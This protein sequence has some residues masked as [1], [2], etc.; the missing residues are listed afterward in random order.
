MTSEG[1]MFEEFVTFQT[2]E[3]F[4]MENLWQGPPPEND[5][6]FSNVT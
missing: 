3:V 2:Y 4:S 5:D 1:G 6:D